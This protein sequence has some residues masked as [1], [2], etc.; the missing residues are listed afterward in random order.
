MIEE[1]PALDAVIAEIAAI[2]TVEPG[3]VVESAGGHG[4]FS[5][6]PA[7]IEL[8]DDGRSAHLLRALTYHGETGVEW[9]VP[10]GAWLDG[11]S[12]PRAF[13]TIIGGPFEGKYREASIVHDHYCITHTRGW[14][15]THRMFHEA[16]LCRGVA[17]FQARIMFYAVYRFGPRWADP[18]SIAEAAPAP[19]LD[20]PDDAAAPSLRRDAAA[21]RA[22]P[23]SVDEIEAMADRSAREAHGAAGR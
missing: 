19:P 11:A 1:Q 3:I 13:W 20:T 5:G 10:S 4:S 16:M 14:R 2:S 23:M 9:P 15:D 22:G 8:G 17:G 18:G 21:L 7:Q 12:I 6:L